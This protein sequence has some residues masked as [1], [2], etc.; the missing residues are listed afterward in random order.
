MHNRPA[1]DVTPYRQAELV[2]LL[3]QFDG[4]KILRQAPLDKLPFILCPALFNVVGANQD[5]A[6]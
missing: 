1:S 3:G 5:Y 2:A 6:V 4:I